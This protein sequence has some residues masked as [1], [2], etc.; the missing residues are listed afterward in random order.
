[1]STSSLALGLFAITGCCAIARADWSNLGGNAG[2][3]GLMPTSGPAT[4]TQVWVR[5]DLPGLIAWAP[6]VEGD[7]M[8]VVRQTQAQNPVTGPGDSIVRCLSLA[9]GAT[10]WS[11]DCPF[12]AGD[13]TTVVYGARDGRVYVGRG[14]NGSSSSAPVYCLS[15]QT[16]AVLWTSAN[17]VATGSYDGVVFLDDGDP[18]FTSNVEVRR[19]DALTGATVWASART[20]SVSGSCGPARDGDAIYL[21][22]T[23]PGGQVISRFSAT[24]GQRQY[25]SPLMPG[26]LCQ[27]SPFCAPGGLVFYLRTQNSASVD[28][29][30]AFR[31]TGSALVLQWSEPARHEFNARHAITPDGGV[32]MLGP[33]GRLQIRDQLTGTL[34]GQS[35]SPVLAASGF[36]SSMTCVDQQGRVFYGNGGGGSPG[37][38]FAFR[39]PTTTAGMLLEWSL[40]GIAG[41]NQGGPVLA[42]D[43]S[44]LVAHTTAIRRYFAATLVNYCTAGTSTAG[45]VASL[46]AT[47]QPRASASSGFTLQATALEGNK[48]ALFFYGISGRSVNAWGPSSSFLCVKSPTQRTP[49]QNSGGV[50]GSCSGSLALDWLAFVAANPTALG[51]PFSSGDVVQAQAWYRDPPSPKTTHLSNALEFTL[52][53]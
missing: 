9:T 31:D 13:W 8:F 12:A 36:Q 52:V 27:N 48:Q 23:A 47:G 51:V 14:G 37:D 38:I 11:F 4:A 33:D 16:G 50:L 30:Y 49:S 21:D 43:G 45:C 7:R 39:S 32:T 15:A 42:A 10:L 3:N 2:A 20:C 18:V 17:E 22:E 1:M 53:P 29:F 26:F 40:P 19:L 28:K 44:L 24:T 41:L 25:S 6:A 35:A 46:S 34:R 5:N